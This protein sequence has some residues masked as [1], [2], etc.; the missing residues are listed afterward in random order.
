LSPFSELWLLK[1]KLW[2]L[3]SL[4]VIV[5]NLGV[6]KFELDDVIL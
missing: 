1:S 4:T 2:M 3:N 6:H 5:L